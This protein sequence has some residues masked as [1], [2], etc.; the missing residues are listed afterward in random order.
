MT[1]VTHLLNVHWQSIVYRL[2]IY[3]FEARDKKISDLPWKI[4]YYRVTQQNS[5]AHTLGQNPTFYPKNPRNFIWKMWMLW[6][7]RF[8]KMW[9]LWTMRHWNCEFCEKWDFENVNFVKNEILKLWILWKM[10]FWNCEFCEIWDFE[11]VNFVILIDFFIS[12]LQKFPGILHG[13]EQEI[14]SHAVQLAQLG[15]RD[16]GQDG[17]R[18]VRDPQAR[19]TFPGPLREGK[20]S[21]CSIQIHR[22]SDAKWTPQDNRFALW[23]GALFIRALRQ[24]CWY[25]SK[26][27][28]FT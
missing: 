4:H 8:L 24:R 10:R 17:R 13:G 25:S 14:R 18:W 16:Q 1:F 12:F 11:I 5:K 2:K 15:Q 3:C 27:L 26:P 22:P 19:R 9:I 23:G 7:M 6:K 20:W 21:C 28:F